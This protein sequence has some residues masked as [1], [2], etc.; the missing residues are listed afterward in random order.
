MA[1]L[2]PYRFPLSLRPAKPKDSKIN[3]IQPIKFRADDN[4]R[5]FDIDGKM[6]QGSGDQGEAD[7]LSK[8]NEEELKRGLDVVKATT[9]AD[10]DESAL[11][12][13]GLICFLL[14]IFNISYLSPS[15]LFS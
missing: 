9:A 11:V 1:V 15:K 4:W 5:Y 2:G 10:E 14:F 7:S 13:S 12:D 6:A 8:L 3:A